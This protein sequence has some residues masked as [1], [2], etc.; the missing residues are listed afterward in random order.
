MGRGKPALSWG[1]PWLLLACVAPEAHWAETRTICGLEDGDVA[2]WP[3]EAPNTNHP[4]VYDA[5]CARAIGEDLGVRW[6]DFPNAD[7]P[8]AMDGEPVERL[9][10]GAY[11]LLAGEFG[12]VADVAADP[13]RPVGFG[14][15]LDALAA[16]LVIPD[17]APASRL[18]YEYVANAVEEVVYVDDGPAWPFSVA[19]FDAESGGI[20]LL[21]TNAYSEV[22][23]MGT[24]VHEASHSVPR[25]VHVDCAGGYG[26][27]DDDWEGA[28][29]VETFVLARWGAGNGERY[30]AL[31]EWHDLEESFCEGAPSD[32]VGTRFLELR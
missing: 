14:G 6:E 9:L 22:D 7:L 1:V 5:D 4:L 29:G 10:A 28:F 21:P 25:R 27:K 24:A 18:F 16:D 8:G 13:L 30:A 11:M 31:L 15:E 12:T 26:G 3:T 23:W 17:D 32:D 2:A 20:N 19:S